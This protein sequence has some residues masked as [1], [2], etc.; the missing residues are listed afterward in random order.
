MPRSL[1]RWDSRNEMALQPDSGELG[2]NRSTIRTVPTTSASSN[3]LV[4][5]LAGSLVLSALYDSVPNRWFE[6]EFERLRLPRW[7][8][9]ILVLAKTSA[10]TGLLVGLRS[11]RLGRLAA[12]ALV[13][14]FV[15]A[16]GAH[17]RVKDEPVRFVPALAM[18]VW[19]VLATQTV[20]TAPSTAA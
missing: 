1:G 18:L 12:H 13:A 8:R 4:V 6:A 5:G 15:L 17:V 3:R 11:S 14:Y 10:A 19:S 20:V 2:R 9:P 7:I 16:I